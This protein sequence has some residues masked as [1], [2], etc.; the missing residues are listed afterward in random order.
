MPK[1]IPT[2]NL[3]EEADEVPDI[4]AHADRSLF[5]VY[6]QQS[7]ASLFLI[8]KILN[9]FRPE[10]IVELGTGKGVLS[11]YFAVYTM[12]NKLAILYTTDIRHVK[13][14]GV[15][16]KIGN[17]RIEKKNIRSLATLNYYAEILNQKKNSLLFVDAGEP[18][19]RDVNRFVAMLNPGTIVLAH[20]FNTLVNDPM[21]WGFK[22]KDVNCWEKLER[23]QPYWDLSI[24]YNARLFCSRV[25]K[26]KEN[27][28][29]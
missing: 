28:N 8:E 7:H 14:Q 21:A 4:F 5:G 16:E 11:I 23:L 1:A 17:V 2:F 20:D 19:S 15:L 9:K 10:R 22:E 18:K 3:P 13:R 12:I 29:A 24:K 25:L 26:P 27:H 6:Y